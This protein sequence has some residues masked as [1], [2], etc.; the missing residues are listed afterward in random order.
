M[1]IVSTMVGITIMGAAAP[2]GMQM[3]LAPVEAQARA[4]NF[5]TAESSAVAFSAANE[6]QEMT[7][8]SIKP[9]N[10]DDPVM[11][12]LSPGAWDV[13]CY[14]GE[15]DSKYRQSVTRSY[16][17]AT[18]LGSSYSWNYDT[19]EN[20]GAHQCPVNDEWGITPRTGFNSVHGDHLGACVPQVAWGENKYLNSDSTKWQYDLRQYADMKG[21]PTHPDFVDG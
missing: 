9:E 7:N 4:R 5:S 17:L 8:L 21:Y 2:S 3:T 20:I 13:T 11:S 10:C 1:N 15:D 6:G 12:P 14:G 16:R 19:P 18:D